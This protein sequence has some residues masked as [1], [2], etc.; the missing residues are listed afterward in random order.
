MSRS[1]L[2]TTRLLLTLN[3]CNIYRSCHFTGQAVVQLEATRGRRRPESEACRRHREGEKLRT[4]VSSVQYVMFKT[5][6]KLLQHTSSKWALLGARPVPLTFMSAPDRSSFAKM[7]SSSVTS[8]ATV[9]RLVWI[10]KI[11]LLVFSSGRGN[12]IFRS[13]LPEEGEDFFYFLQV[14]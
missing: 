3:T 5:W 6:V 8:S 7:R 4:S 11:L 14:P 12:S 10:W 1:S 13:I 2:R 9:M